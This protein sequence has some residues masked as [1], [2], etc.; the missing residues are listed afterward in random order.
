MEIRPEMLEALQRAAGVV[1]GCDKHDIL[2]VRFSE[3]WNGEECVFTRCFRIAFHLYRGSRHVLFD[4]RAAIL[5]AIARAGRN[6]AT[7]LVLSIEFSS[8]PGARIRNAP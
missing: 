4:K 6:H 2:C 5:L 3:Q 1:P 8:P 7:H